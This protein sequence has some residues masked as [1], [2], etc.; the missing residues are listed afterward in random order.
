[1]YL[2]IEDGKKIAMPR[3]YKN[4]IYDEHTRQLVGKK[5]YEK[6]LT[7]QAKQI[8]KIGIDKYTWNQEQSIQQQ[9]IKY[10][11]NVKKDKL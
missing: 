2:N 9:A 1:M 7:D 11:K 3:Y 4:K 10:F 8:Q 6:M 5:A